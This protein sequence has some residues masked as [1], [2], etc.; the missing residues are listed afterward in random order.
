[1]VENKE[2]REVYAESLI[3]L[4]KKDERVVLVEADLMMAAKTVLFQQQFPDRVID[5]GVAEANMVGVAAGMAA[6]GKVPF[7]HS[8]CPFA[9]RRCYDQLAISVAYAGL[10]VKIA[11]TDPGVTAELNG[12]THMSFEDI[13]IMR[14]LPSM[15]IFEPTD[16]VQL[17]QAMP[18]I[19]KHNGP[20]YLRIFRKTKE[21]VFNEDYKFNW[22]KASILEEGMDASIIAS[23]IMVKTSLN[24]AKQLAEEGINVRV[25]NM[26]TI[27]PIDKE[28]ILKA[29]Y[30]TGAIVTAENHNIINGLGS[31]V[32]E[33]LIENVPVPMKRIGMKDCFG[34]VGKMEFLLE[35]YEMTEKDI[36]K[37]VK[38]VI[39]IKA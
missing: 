15:V 23:G 1:M 18:Y 37:A 29:A 24:A 34:E 33:V 36:I 4:A 22:C 30:D 20:V 26:H 11:G 32:A 12:A 2:L 27:K 9:T 28:S 7:I 5:V 19:L 17:K 13:G 25:I 3:E 6:F 39:R 16:A 38:K 14:N 8:F 10:N 31:A 35:K 21:I